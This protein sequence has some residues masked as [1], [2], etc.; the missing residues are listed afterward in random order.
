[1]TSCASFGRGGTMPT[2]KQRL[3]IAKKALRWIARDNL[4]LDGLTARRA[5]AEMSRVKG[6]K[7]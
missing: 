6:R 1:M 3:A 7:G 5:L 2:D 4:G